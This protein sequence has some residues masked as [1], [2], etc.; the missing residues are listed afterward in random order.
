MAK[1]DFDLAEA[2]INSKENTNNMNFHEYCEYE[3]LHHG[4]QSRD[5]LI[6]RKRNVLK[7]VRVTKDVQV[8]PELLC[9]SHTLTTLLINFNGKGLCGHA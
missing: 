1:S 9:S 3:Y 6:R 2:L 8:K 4:V 5:T 7:I